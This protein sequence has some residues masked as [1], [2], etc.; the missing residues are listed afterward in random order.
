MRSR[1]VNVVRAGEAPYYLAHIRYK[2]SELYGPEITEQGGLDIIA[3]MD[4]PL[5]LLAEKTLKE[6]VR[7]I[8]P[9][10]QGSLLALDPNT[11]NILA[12]VGGIDFNK[13]PY[14]RAFFAKRQAGSAIK[15]L[16]YAAALEEGYTAS[17]IFNDE[18]VTYNPG[19][20]NPWTPKN[21][22]HKYYGDLTLRQALAHSNNVIAVKLL[23]EIG[24]PHFEEFANRLGLPLHTPN[25]L[26]V[27][28]GTDEV[29]L[30]DL[31]SV[32]APL[33]NGGIKP[34]TRTILRIFDR[35]HQTWTE[36]PSVSQTV[37][38]AGAAYVTTQMLKDVLIYGTA[39]AL[40]S[41]SLKQPAAGKTGHHRRLP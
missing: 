24:V 35:N 13:N 38:S 29:T 26:S 23:D 19:G 36:M 7:R 27:A 30:H 20:T 9:E 1:T 34:Q 6:G 22:N 16:I 18:L 14:D 31:V 2:L 28:L 39:R 40:K 32:Y 25:N 37:L 8:N 17:D 4:L 12:A 11:G 33:A 21:Y 41:F 3:A 15:P 5:Q 10:L